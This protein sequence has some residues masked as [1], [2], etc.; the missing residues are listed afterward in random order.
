[1]NTPYFLWDYELNDNQIRAILNGKNEIEK[2]WLVARILTHAKYEDV[3]KYL[4]LEEIIAVFPRLRLPEK[5][6][7]AW[8]RAFAV[9][10]YHV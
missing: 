5:T 7:Q 2:Q 4:T 1:M 6:K 10:G 9:W 8:H 3:W